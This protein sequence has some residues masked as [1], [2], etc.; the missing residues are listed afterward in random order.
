MTTVANSETPLVEGQETGKSTKAEL[1]AI[2]K[3]E[4]Q[5]AC[6]EFVKLTDLL[7]DLDRDHRERRE[8][9]RG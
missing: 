4:E 6:G 5:I 9:K 2:R 1:A 7:H 8:K 3:G